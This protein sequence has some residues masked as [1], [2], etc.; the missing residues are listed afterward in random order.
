M[1]ARCGRF[2]CAGG[3]GTDFL[4]DRDGTVGILLTQ[5]E[6]GE[7]SWPMLEEFQALHVAD[8]LG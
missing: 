6:L 1:A 5:V 8:D 4:V 3:Q 7:K 2:G